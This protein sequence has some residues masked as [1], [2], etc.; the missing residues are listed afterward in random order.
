MFYI[1]KCKTEQQRIF[2]KY[3]KNEVKKEFGEN[4]LAIH[5]VRDLDFEIMQSIKSELSFKLVLANGSCQSV[6]F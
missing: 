3:V 4:Y 6:Y 1:F 2:N 5:Q